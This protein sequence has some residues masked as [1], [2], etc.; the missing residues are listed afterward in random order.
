[1][2]ETIEDITIQYEEDGIV[3]LKELDKEILSKGAWCTIVFRYQQL[4][5]KTEEY[6]SDKYTIRR[7]R[8]VDGEYKQ[9]LKFNISSEKQAHKLVEILNKWL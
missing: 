4:D 2:F 1:M 8:K 3:L 7:Y 9:Q 5:K 6:G